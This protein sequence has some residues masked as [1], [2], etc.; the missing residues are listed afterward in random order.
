M[1]SYIF[2]DMADF[3]HIIFHMPKI[4]HIIF[5]IWLILEK[6]GRSKSP[7]PRRLTEGNLTGQAFS[8]V[9]QQNASKE[10]THE[11]APHHRL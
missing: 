7:L 6:N 2:F 5:D 8:T 9:T 11:K 10:A 3:R 1:L 4:R